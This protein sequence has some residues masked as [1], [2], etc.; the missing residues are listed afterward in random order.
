MASA[1][2][3]CLRILPVS[4]T[5]RPK[6]GA[7]RRR[8]GESD[9]GRLPSECAALTGSTTGA[10]GGGGDQQAGAGGADP[11]VSG[12]PEEE[13]GLAP[14]TTQARSES[15][16]RETQPESGGSDFSAPSHFL[17][18]SSSFGSQDTRGRETGE[19]E[20]G[21]HGS[22]EP[23]GGADHMP[24][25]FTEDAGEGLN[26]L[27]GLS[28]RLREDRPAGGRREET[29]GPSHNLSVGKDSSSRR[30][31]RTR[32]TGGH[33]SASSVVSRLS[34]STATALPTSWVWSVSDGS[35]HRTGNT[36]TVEQVSDV[37]LSTPFFSI[38][39]EQDRTAPP[40]SPTSPDVSPPVQFLAHGYT[41][42]SKG[43]TASSPVEHAPLPRLTTSSL[44]GSGGG[45]SPQGRTWDPFFDATAEPAALWAGLQQGESQVDAG[46]FTEAPRISWGRSAQDFGIP[47]DRSPHISKRLADPPPLTLRLERAKRVETEETTKESLIP[48]AIG[49]I[50]RAAE[51]PSTL[52]G[53]LVW[54]DPLEEM[55]EMLKSKMQRAQMPTKRGARLTRRHQRF[56]AEFSRLNIEVAKRRKAQL[57][58]SLTMLEPRSPV[59]TGGSEAGQRAQTRDLLDGTLSRAALRELANMFELQRLNLTSRDDRRDP[60]VKRERRR[61]IMSALRVAARLQQAQDTASE[62]DSKSDSDSNEWPGSR[63]PLVFMSQPLDESLKEGAPKPV[64][65]QRKE[66][67]TSS[68]PPGM[69][70]SDRRVSPWL[71]EPHQKEQWHVKGWEQ[72]SALKDAEIKKAAQRR[73]ARRRLWRQR[74]SS[75]SSIAEEAADEL[76]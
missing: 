76:E 7:S 5:P 39:G 17:P 8:P 49:S 50:P 64:P 31:R 48:V 26:I 59:P 2:V 29:Q 42:G 11:V 25:V 62:D 30:R 56:I 37:G 16:G 38:L 27:E 4:G 60:V 41:G 40:S 47:S 20:P 55:V 10:Q 75:L 21:D 69:M 65:D 18:G 19:G 35:V 34:S 53:A 6:V 9:K 71:A 67:F 61:V 51:P 14:P 54:P 3:K 52:P 58:H 36:E 44:S 28:S 74:P 1:W 70:K 45:L 15:A 22:H 57:E 23:T 72:V 73:H 33:S 24:P 68:G 32:K 63:S 12:V 66:V 46:A 13:A 43:A